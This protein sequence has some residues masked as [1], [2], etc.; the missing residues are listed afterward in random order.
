MK[1]TELRDRL[2]KEYIHT[3]QNDKNS[4]DIDENLYWGADT[5]KEYNNAL[6]E[7]EKLKIENNIYK[8]YAW[9]DISGF[10][11]WMKKQEEQNYLQIS[12][13]IKKS[14]ISEENYKKLVKDIFATI[15]KA[16]KII[17]MYNIN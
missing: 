9:V 13:T 8:I 2:E 11:Y 7:I 17:Q 14:A 1:N 6:E 16:N 10:E 4:F 5:K 15:D 12:F 3:Q